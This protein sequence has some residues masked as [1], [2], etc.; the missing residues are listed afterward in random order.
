MADSHRPYGPRPPIAH[1]A[2]G[3]GGQRLFL[4]LVLAGAAA[5]AF[6]ML[7]E[8]DKPRPATP[9]SVPQVTASIGRITLGDD[10]SLHLSVVSRRDAPDVYY[11]VLLSDA[12]PGQRLPLLCE[13]VDPEGRIARRNH[14][15]TR[16]ITKTPWP[17]HAHFR[18]D[19]AAPVGLWTVR[20]VHGGRT[21]IETRFEVVDR[22]GA[23]AGAQPT[24]SPATRPGPPPGG[25]AKPQAADREAP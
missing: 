11:R 19:P 5:G 6:W 13:W 17:T 16:E 12:P 4:L 1:D 18:F 8:R 23:V 7:R 25:V 10:D 3:F 14:Y 22:S 15:Q 9:V 2:S 24:T 20:L 21:L